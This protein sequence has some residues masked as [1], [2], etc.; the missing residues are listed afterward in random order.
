[1][2]R[3]LAAILVL[4]CLCVA[5]LGAQAKFLPKDPARTNAPGQFPIV[6]TPVTLKVFVPSIGFIKDFKTNSSAVW[7]EKLTNVKIEWIET[8]KV[9]AKNKLSIMMASGDYPDIIFGMSGSGISVQDLYR[10]GRQGSFL[11]MNDMIDAYGFYIKELLKSDPDMKQAMMSPDGKIY[12]LPAVFTDDYHMT[13]RQKMWI[14]QAWLSKLGLRM[15]TTLEE[16]YN[17]LKAF[18]TRDP[19]GNGLADEIPMTGAKR[20]QEDLA[21]WLMNAFLPAGGPDDGADATLNNYEFIINSKV[22]FDADKPEFREGLRYIAKMFR[23]GL[24]DVAGLTQDKAQIKPLVD[25][26][27]V[28]VGAVASHHPGNFSSLSNDMSAPFHMYKAL[29]PVSGPQGKRYTPWIIDQVIQPGQFVITDRCKNP[30]V[31][32][33]WGD[34]FFKLETALVDKGV[35]GIHWAKVDPKEGLIALNG[36]PANYK[37][38]KV[39]TPDD[40]AQINIGPIWTR[41]LKNEFAKSAG[42]SYEEFLY[43]AT[44]LYE[45]YKIARYP[46]AT[47]SVSEKD[48]TEFNDLR[49][50]IHSYVGESVDRFIIGDLDIDKKWEDYVRQ[51]NQIGLSRYLK[52]LQDAF[53]ASMD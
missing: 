29:P 19:N 28:R 44:K 46:Y 4:A 40:N 34:S 45:P 16:L 52:I 32:F 26:G 10:Y 15:P 48:S 5:G 7:H 6:Q 27:I 8:S 39:L 25:G 43:N 2:K 24:I 11:P 30:L 53:T 17:V 50:T 18:K 1:M 35:E 23:E 37:Y 42:Y 12:G 38:L 41:D 31:A 21:M 22:Y 36:K 47:A 13:M 33:L 51:L 14:N 20:S 9:D 3:F 49:R